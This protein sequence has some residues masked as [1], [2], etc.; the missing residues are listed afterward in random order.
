VVLIK[1]GD[2]PDLACLKSGGA[3]EKAAVGRAALKLPLAL[4]DRRIDEMCLD[5]AVRMVLQTLLLRRNSHE[6]ERAGALAYGRRVVR[7]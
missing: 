7:T 6:L 4:C 5:E 3:L 1:R 2:P